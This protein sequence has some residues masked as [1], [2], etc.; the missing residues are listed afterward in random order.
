ML[1]MPLIRLYERCPCDVPV[2]CLSVFLSLQAGHTALDQAR[3]HNNPDVALL[4][5]KAPQVR[6]A[7]LEALTSSLRS[8][9]VMSKYLRHP[10]LHRFRSLDA[11]D[12]RFYM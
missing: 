5:T 6:P 9:G 11:A 1:I 12:V 8:L 3:E 10:K 7:G 4:L 2:I